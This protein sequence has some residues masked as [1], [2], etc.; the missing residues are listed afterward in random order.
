MQHAPHREDGASHVEAVE[1]LRERPAR[2]RRRVSL[3]DGSDTPR[4]GAPSVA[5]KAHRKA[6][7][8][9]MRA[10][11]PLLPSGSLSGQRSPAIAPHCL[12]MSGSPSKANGQPRARVSPCRRA[13]PLRQERRSPVPRSRNPSPSETSRQARTWTAST[14]NGRQGARDATWTGRGSPTRAR[15]QGRGS[16]WVPRGAQGRPADVPI[17]YREPR[18]GAGHGS[19]RAP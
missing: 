5:L 10:R 15:G 3:P 18:D 14:R 9:P 2:A 8:A 7:V 11:E 4:A 12:S 19:A 17:P 16:L 13:P 1:V 6:K